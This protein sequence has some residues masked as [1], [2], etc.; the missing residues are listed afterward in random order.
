MTEGNEWLDANALA[1]YHVA[2][3]ER[4]EL[5]IPPDISACVSL[6]KCPES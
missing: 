1:V 5:K 6:S 2:E 4:G 3:G